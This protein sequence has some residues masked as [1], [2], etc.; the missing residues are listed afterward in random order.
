[1]LFPNAEDVRN[2]AT[3]ALAHIDEVKHL[4]KRT[5]TR[6][7]NAAAFCSF[8]V[9]TESTGVGKRDNVLL[10]D[11][12]KT[13]SAVIIGIYQAVGKSFSESLVY[14]RVVNAVAAFKFERNFNILRDLVV[15]TEIE[16]VNVSTPITRRGYDRLL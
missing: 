8:D 3:C 15:N 6:V 1:M 7:G 16:I 13:L 11:D 2:T 12:N 4:D 5:V 14:G 10:F 9:D